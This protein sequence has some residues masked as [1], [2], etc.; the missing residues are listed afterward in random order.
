[1]TDPLG[2]SQVLPYLNGLSKTGKYKFV[3]VSF[4][5]AKNFAQ[6]GDFIKEYCLEA[7]II[8]HPLSYTAKPPV[9]STFRDVQR[10]KKLTHE[11]VKKYSFSLVHCRS[12]IPALTG[13]HLKKKFSISFLFDMRSFWADE[14]VEGGLWALSN[15][16]YRLIYKYFKKKE[17]QFL[18]HSDHIV[19]LTHNAKKEILSW[20]L[21][22]PIASITIIPCCVDIDMFNPA[23]ISRQQKIE[24]YNS[25]GIPVEAPVISYLGS[26]GTWYMLDEML[27]FVKAY[28]IAQPD[29]YFM[30]LTH[31]SELTIVKA[32]GLA[33]VDVN[34][35]RVKKV[36]RKEVPVYLSLSKFSLFFI[37]PV[38]SKKAS[39]PVKQGEIMAMGVPVVCNDGVGDTSEIVEKSSAGYVIK[40]FTMTAYDKI[41]KELQTAVFDGS[42]I[43]KGAVNFFS[44]SK[45]ISLYESVYMQMI[46]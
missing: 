12:Y 22:F 19:S 32:A 45:G 20:K 23:T 17:K 41:I 37:K 25:L 43:R 42:D 38:F 44:L 26:I 2:Q 34:Y 16:L 8:W 14:R 7:G 10:M 15:P 4:E 29:T 31:D 24:A 21:N 18:Q 36:Q 27:A 9:W 30:I 13:L 3:L 46:K 28:Q 11:L 33:N 39:S 35:L 1:M 40:E 5:K 6:L